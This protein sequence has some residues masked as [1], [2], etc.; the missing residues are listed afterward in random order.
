MFTLTSKVYEN[1]TYKSFIIFF[2]FQK[3]FDEGKIFE[4]VPFH[5]P[6]KPYFFVQKYSTVAILFN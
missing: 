2:V 5:A 3:W 4:S 1:K 6:N